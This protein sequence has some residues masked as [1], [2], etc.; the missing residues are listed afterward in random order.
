MRADHASL[1]SIAL[2]AMLEAIPSPTIKSVHSVGILSLS[3]KLCVVCKA[4]HFI[5]MLIENQILLLQDA[6]PLAL[7]TPGTAIY[8]SSEVFEFKAKIRLQYRTLMADGSTF[9][10]Q[11]NC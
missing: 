2:I 7:L 9:H 11:F 6:D 1:S 5:Q 8:D 10:F 4:F 3:K